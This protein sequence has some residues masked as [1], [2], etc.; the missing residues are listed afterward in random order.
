MVHVL[1]LGA[2]GREQF[3]D[4]LHMPV[5]RTADIKEQQ[6]LHGIAPLRPQFDVKIA[7]M[8]RFFNGP[9]E[10]ELFERAGA[11]KLA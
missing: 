2:G 3:L 9:V 6:H 4:D 10:I 5:H 11:G 8:R 7:A 1:E